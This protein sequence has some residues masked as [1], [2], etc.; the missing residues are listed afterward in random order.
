VGPASGVEVVLGGVV[1]GSPA[2]PPGVVAV[3][4]APGV[5][6]AESVAVDVSFGSSRLP[7]AASSAAA[8]QMGIRNFVPIKAP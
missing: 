7:Q 3:S 4:P 8:A 1:L 2:L 6:P 5:V